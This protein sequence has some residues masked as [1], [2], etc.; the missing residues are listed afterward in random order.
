MRDVP[1]TLAAAAACVERGELDAAE[2][3]SRSVLRANPLCPR[4]LHV[5]GVVARKTDRL[6]LAIA[7]L[8]DAARLTPDDAGIHCELALAL[9]DSRREDEAV[10]HYRRAIEINPQYG[11]ACLNLAAALDRLEQI[12]AAL[13]W[14]QRAAELQTNS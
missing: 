2:E 14:A 4:A 3:L 9:S 11:D 6:Q 13:P 8:Q 1:A 7:V 12:E 5:L 10:V